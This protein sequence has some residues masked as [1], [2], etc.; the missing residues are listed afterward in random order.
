M[1]VQQGRL[2]ATDTTKDMENYYNDAVASEVSDVDRSLHNGTQFARLVMRRPQPDTARGASFASPD[3]QIEVDEWIDGAFTSVGPVSPAD[4][5]IV[6]FG[7]RLVSTSQ[8]RLFSTTAIDSTPS[9]W[10]VSTSLNNLDSEFSDSSFE[11][12]IDSVDA[13][14]VSTPVGNQF[15]YTLN[16]SAPSIDTTGDGLPWWR[17]AHTG[18]SAFAFVTEV[19]PL[20]PLTPTISYFDTDGSFASSF[21][22][23]QDNIL[24]ACYDTPN[25]RFYTIRFNTDNVG[26]SSISLSDDFSDADAGTASGTNNFNPAR[27]EESSANPQFLRSSGQLVYNV[28]DGNGQLET[29]YTLAN[30]FSAVIDVNPI[31]ITNDEQWFTLRAL[32]DNNNT[33]MSEGV[34]YDAAPTA[35]GIWFSSYMANLSN[36][37]ASC[38]LREVRPLIHNAQTGTDSFVISYDGANWNVS[39]TLT[40]ALT[41]ASTGSLYTESTDPSTPLEFLISCTATPTVGEQFSFDLITTTTDKSPTATGIIGITRTGTSWDS[42]QGLVSGATVAADPV[43]IELFGNTTGSIDL[44]ADN[45]DVSGTGVF[46]QIAVFTVEKTDDEGDVTGTP[47]IESFDIIGDP[48]LTYNDFLDGRV[49]IACTSSGSGGGHVYIKVN[50]VLYKYANNVSLGT[51]D[52]TSASVSSTAQIAK[53]GTT[54]LNWTHESGI[55]GTPFLTYL[56]YDETLDIVHVKTIDKDTLLDTTDT[57]EVLLDI[58][59]YNTNRYTI[60]F[61]QNDFDTLYYVDNST[62]LQ[63]FN[64]DDRI[65]AFMAVNAEDTT[66]PAGTSQATVVTA[67]VINAWGEALDGKDVTFQVTTGDGAVSPST[68]TTVS[69]GRAFTQFVVGATVGVST[70]TATVTEGS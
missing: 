8:I 42:A 1:A 6:G 25:S 55:G 23:E 61:D 46:P 58:S 21:P 13:A 36:S 34:G 24:D 48:S 70:V 5:V 59:D 20:P 9:A 67:D 68:D 38:Q 2:G 60:F 63:A 37:T 7:G 49:Q 54:S 26:T 57:K 40:G 28:A 10:T 65:S 43:S 22:F 33:I 3:T 11:A 30:D 16:I 17:V 14:I 52:G 41:D 18:S 62:N 12:T 66:L 4:L 51:E 32:D 31:D 50:N 56:E 53:D 39:G 27:W 45:Y 35:T 29:T 19:Q 64:L 47:L 15:R 69:G 44:Q